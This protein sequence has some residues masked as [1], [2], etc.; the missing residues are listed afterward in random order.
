MTTE[1]IP[2]AAIAMLI[3]G[4]LDLW[5]DMST[6]SWGVDDMYQ[7]IGIP[8][9]MHVSRPGEPLSVGISWDEWRLH[10]TRTPYASLKS[11]NR[12]H[13]LCIPFMGFHLVPIKDDEGGENNEQS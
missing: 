5:L 13:V 11:C 2:A 7:R 6:S 1:R 8:F 10:R 4:E 12:K 3:S 9:P